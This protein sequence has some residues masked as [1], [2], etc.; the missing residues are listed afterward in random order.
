V[1]VKRESIGEKIKAPAD[2][3]A[4]LP[5]INIQNALNTLNIDKEVFKRILIGFLEN[6]KDTMG[7]MRDFF[8]KKDW[9]SLRMMAHSLKG[10]AGNIGAEKLWKAAME[11]ETASSEAAEKPPDSHFIDNM[12]TELERVLKSLQSLIEAPETGSLREIRVQADST[13]V[14][15]VLGELAGALRAA[16]PQKIE[17]YLK[18]AKTLLGDSVFQ[19]FER[20]VND[21]DYDEALKVLKLIGQKTGVILD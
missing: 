6:N 14:I 3:P 12:E 4:R 2:L 10:S 11:L 7:R 19:D 18:T 5:G 17:R 1:G 20:L 15:S 13:E 9:E 16:D 21:Y 8:S